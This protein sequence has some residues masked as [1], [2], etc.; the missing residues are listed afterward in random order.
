[1]K[2]SSHIDILCF[3]RCGN[4]AGPHYRTARAPRAFGLLVNQNPHPQR[5]SLR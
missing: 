2:L 3:D 4:V 1:M 5:I